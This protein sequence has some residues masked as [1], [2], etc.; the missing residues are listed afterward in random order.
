MFVKFVGFGSVQT[1][2]IDFLEWTQKSKCEVNCPVKSI[3]N[4]VNFM[5]LK[6]NKFLVFNCKTIS[7]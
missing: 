3:K 4:A 5:S 1:E 6:N 2:R 7:Y